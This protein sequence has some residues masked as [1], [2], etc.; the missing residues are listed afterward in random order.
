ML[1]FNVSANFR[2][3][4][5]MVKHIPGLVEKAATRSLNRTNDQVATI[6]RRLI[7][8]DMGVSIKTVRAGMSKVKARRSLLTAT[9]IAKDKPLNLI[10]FKSRQTKRGV[11]ASAWGRR[12]VYKGTFIGNQGR[13]V[14]R[15]TSKLRLPIKPVWGPSIPAVM[16]QDAIVKAMAEHARNQWQ[17]NFAR[18]MQFYLDRTRF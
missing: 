8:K 13:T 6:A 17:K 7:A 10:R 9:T 16:L 11:S 12:K 2:E 14:F 15:R 18:D 3:V 1:D 5:R 4:E